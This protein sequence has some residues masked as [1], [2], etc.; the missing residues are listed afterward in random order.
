[1]LAVNPTEVE[2]IHSSHVQRENV[3][4]KVIEVSCA[5]TLMEAQMMMLK[6]K[7]RLRLMLKEEL[8][9][10]CRKQKDSAEPVTALL[11]VYWLL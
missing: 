11:G 3:A 10:P 9:K 5:G 2:T 1:M 6:Q 7:L 4:Y 8:Y